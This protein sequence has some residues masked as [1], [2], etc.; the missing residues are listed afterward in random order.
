MTMMLQDFVEL[1]NENSR[2][3]SQISD[4]R[5]QIIDLNKRLAYLEYEH[6]EKVKAEKDLQRFKDAFKPLIGD[7]I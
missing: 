7:L 2:L 1:S 4:L 6:R 5:F 3:R